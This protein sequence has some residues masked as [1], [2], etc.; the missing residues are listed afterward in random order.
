[1]AHYRLAKQGVFLSIQGEGVLLGTPMIFVR[2]AG[3]SVGCS[4]C[5]TDY[6]FDSEVTLPDLL[7]RVSRADYPGCRWVWL[8]GGEPTDQNLSPLL[9][10]LRDKGYRVALATSGVRPVSVGLDRQAFDFLSVSPHHP[11]LL[12]QWRGSQVNLVPGLNGVRLVE[13]SD[14]RKRLEEGFPTRFVTPC[15]GKPETLEECLRWV[16]CHPE[17]RLGCQAHKVWR[18]P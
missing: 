8:T 3:C 6:A 10:S 7:D 2:L 4:G 13:W 11:G 9:A 5:D 1:M 17:W 16:R 14:D 15:A 18:I 12:T